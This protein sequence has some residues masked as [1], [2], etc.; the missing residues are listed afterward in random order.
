MVQND[1][2]VQVGD[3]NAVF[4]DESKRWKYSYSPKKKDGTLKKKYHDMP[5][6]KMILQYEGE[7]KRQ[8]AEKIKLMVQDTIKMLKNN[9]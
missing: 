7:M 6:F 5:R 4:D 2:S 3:F 1:Q 8:Y 9:A